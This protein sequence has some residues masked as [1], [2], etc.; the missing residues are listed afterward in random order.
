ML[1][2]KKVERKAPVQYTVRVVFTG[3]EEESRRVLAEARRYAFAR[4]LEKIRR[5]K[6]EP[7]C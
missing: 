7:L 6:N 4:I 5:E 3:T 2:K 1:A